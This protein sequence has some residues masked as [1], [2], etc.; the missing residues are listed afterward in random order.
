MHQ[1]NTLWVLIFGEPYECRGWKCSSWENDA[2]KALI[3]HNEPL[4]LRVCCWMSFK[5]VFL[6]KW[7]FLGLIP[8]AL[9]TGK[10]FSST[11]VPTVSRTVFCGLDWGIAGD[12]TITFTWSSFAWQWQAT[13]D[14]VALQTHLALFCNTVTTSDSR[15]KWTWLYRTDTETETLSHS[16]KAQNKLN[17]TVYNLIRPLLRTEWASTDNDWLTFT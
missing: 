6:V 11:I 2:C 14:L 7:S 10:P 12:K 13:F 17:H 9:E 3:V 5:E 16:Q 8:V 15:R 1:T 4:S